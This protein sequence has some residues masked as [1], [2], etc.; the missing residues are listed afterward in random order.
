MVQV[1]WSPRAI[2][3]LIAIRDYIGEDSPIAAQRM[4]QRLKQA[5]DLLATHPDR[6]RAA[7]RRLREL[8]V[9]YPYLIRYRVSAGQVEIVRIKHGA[10][11]PDG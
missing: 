2:A 5:G 4:A 6:G 7:S 9:I 11:R 1:V 10:Q 3:D 8:T